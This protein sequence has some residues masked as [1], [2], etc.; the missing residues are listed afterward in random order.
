MLQ[1]VGSEF[2]DATIPL[3][4]F[5]IMVPGIRP[6]FFDEAI[7]NARRCQLLDPLIDKL[8][9]LLFFLLGVRAML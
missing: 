9:T 2:T 8:R 1:E 7:M 3:R 6:N 4:L 5:Q